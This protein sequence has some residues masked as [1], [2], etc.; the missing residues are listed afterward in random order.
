MKRAPIWQATGP[1]RFVPDMRDGLGKE[2]F[3][4]PPPRS[5]LE[6]E[7]SEQYDRETAIAAME[8]IW[9]TRHD[10]VWEM[11]WAFQYDY[12]DPEEEGRHLTLHLVGH[13]VEFQ[14]GETDEPELRKR[15]AATQ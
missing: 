4:P 10:L 8:F 3:P 1:R 6:P 14:I 5:D 2:L 15:I 12:D 13:L 7:P 11:L 9:E